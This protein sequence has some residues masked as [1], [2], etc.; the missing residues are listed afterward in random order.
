MRQRRSIRSTLSR[1]LLAI[2][3]IPDTCAPFRADANKLIMGC[4]G[5]CYLVITNPQYDR[6][7]KLETEYTH[8]LAR[9]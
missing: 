7:R 4:V 3:I 5:E 6:D 8:K 1:E 9:T 2:V